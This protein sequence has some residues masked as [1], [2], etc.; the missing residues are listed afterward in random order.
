LGKLN[1]GSSFNK[2]KE[3]EEEEEEEEE[4]LRSVEF[5]LEY[6]ELIAGLDPEYFVVV[7]ETWAAVI[8]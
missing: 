1:V 8:G 4:D 2:G 6:D 3:E 5:E 7:K